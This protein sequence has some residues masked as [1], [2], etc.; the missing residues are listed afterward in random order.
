MTLLILIERI[1]LGI[2]SAIEEQYHLLR[3]KLRTEP[4][5]PEQLT[6]YAKY[7]EQKQQSS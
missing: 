5:T 2:D 6:G 4:F 3:V 1:D 7:I